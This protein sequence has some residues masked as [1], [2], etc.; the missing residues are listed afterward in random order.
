MGETEFK[1]K[2]DIRGVNPYILITKEIAAKIKMG[3]KRPMPVLVK[4][5]ELPEKH[6]KINMMP[7]GNGDFYLYLHGTLRKA[8][9][10]KVGDIVRVRVSFDN[11]YRGGP[12]HSMPEKF[13]DALKKD[14]RALESWEKLSPSRKKEILRYFANIKRDSALQH[15][16]SRAISVLGGNNE[17]F[18]GRE[19]KDGK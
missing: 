19:W 9:N 1:S 11:K 3:W 12:M 17:R 14:K 4:I 7:A 8:S 2:I 5:N 15:N 10:T 16:I 6:W 18:M 13:E